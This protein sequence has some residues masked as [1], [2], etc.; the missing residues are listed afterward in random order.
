LTDRDNDV[1]K[2][3]AGTAQVRR[4][5]IDVYV[6]TGLLPVSRGAPERKLETHDR[7]DR[8][9]RVVAYDTLTP[10]GT[11]GIGFRVV[12]E[13]PFDFEPGEFVGI[14]HEVP[15]VG[16]RRTP[17]CITSPPGPNR[18][19]RLIVRLV[20]DGPL[21]IYL[22]DL[23]V[24]D[25]INFRGPN[26][27]SMV[28]KEPDTDLIM[29]GTGVGIGPFL[30]LAGHVLV[31]DDFAA[32]RL[33]VYWGLR[34]VDDI[35]LLDE[36][37]ALAAAHPNFE[38][39]ITL[40]QPPPGWSGLRGRVTESVPP[41]LETLGDKHFYLVGNG[42]MIEEM[43]MTLSDR[44]V[45]RKLIYEERYFNVR[46][47]PD[48]ATLERIRAGYVA[49][50]IISPQDEREAFEREFRSRPPVSQVRSAAER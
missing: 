50:D 34:L 23:K 46:Y 49:A 9:A 12:D 31:S 17:Y 28:P 1:T 40:S 13:H 29:L 7:Y 33:I 27:R 47:H 3:P 37:D 22:G 43:A 48:A 36:L 16:S 14:R 2:A 10:T 19:F 21:S 20:P 41:L 11:V 18:E 38:Y 15:G 5:D 26:G 35:C 25:E 4:R 24:G 8:V 6:P 32:R 42:A 39:H 30:S 45:D 44:G